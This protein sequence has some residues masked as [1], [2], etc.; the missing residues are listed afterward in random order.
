MPTSQLS[1]PVSVEVSPLSARL[2]RACRVNSS[3][4]RVHIR[5]G[6]DRSTASIHAWYVRSVRRRSSSFAASS[7]SPGSRS[8]MWMQP[9]LHLSHLHFSPPSLRCR[10]TA[11]SLPILCRP[12]TQYHFEAKVRSLVSPRSLSSKA[13]SSL[14]ASGS[15]KRLRSPLPRLD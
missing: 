15:P 12:C 3:V 6:I 9:Q 1:P 13:I 5:A 4:K 7:K 2:W 8:M 10:L 11:A 14:H